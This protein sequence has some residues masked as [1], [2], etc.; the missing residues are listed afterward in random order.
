MGFQKGQ[1]V[2]RKERGKVLLAKLKLSF[3]EK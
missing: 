1:I 3:L 2:Y